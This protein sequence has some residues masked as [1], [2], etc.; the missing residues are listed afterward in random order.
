MP[1]SAGAAILRDSV[2]TALDNSWENVPEA[3]YR[4]FGQ[5]NSTA[6][7]TGFGLEA[8]SKGPQWRHP[9]LLRVKPI[10]FPAL[11]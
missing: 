5:G 2:Y 4:G 6:Y 11:S 10:S 7:G 9:L 8:S 3:A 1:S